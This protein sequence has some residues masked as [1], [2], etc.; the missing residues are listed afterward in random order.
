MSVCSLGTALHSPLMKAFCTPT[1]TPEHICGLRS[2]RHATQAYPHK[3]HEQTIPAHT[4]TLNVNASGLP[5]GYGASPHLDVED[6][7]F[8]NG[9]ILL[10]TPLYIK[11]DRQGMRGVAPNGAGD[12]WKI[13]V[14]ADCRGEKM[15]QLQSDGCIWGDKRALMCTTMLFSLVTSLHLLPRWSSSLT[16]FIAHRPIH[17]VSASKRAPLQFRASVLCVNYISALFT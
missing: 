2:Y 15:L 17:A 4:K 6:K 14:G 10:L 11:G 5:D 9:H 8:Y 1:H 7:L 13:T 3:T 16:V 12:G